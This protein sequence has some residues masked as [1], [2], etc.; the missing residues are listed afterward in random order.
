MTCKTES[1]SQTGGRVQEGKL[2]QS[3]K[4]SLSKYLLN[5]YCVPGTVRGS[6]NGAVNQTKTSCPQEPGAGSFVWQGHVRY[7]KGSY[8]CINPI[9]QMGKQ[10][11]VAEGMAQGGTARERQI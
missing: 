1:L 10:G 2:I 8:V 5:A 3:F 9:L 11:R 7:R 4:Q 6:G